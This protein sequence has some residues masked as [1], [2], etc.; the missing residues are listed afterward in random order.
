VTARLAGEEGFTLV[1]LLVA[2]IVGLVV[3]FAAF[4]VMDGSWRVNA[5]TTDHI[6]TTNRGRL[7]MDK[8]I[9]QLGSRTCLQSETPAQG[10]IVTATDNVIEYYASVTQEAAPRL[11]VE[12]RRLTYRP[13]TQDILLQAWTGTAPPPKPP[14]AAPTAAN[15][16]RVIAGGLAPAGSTPIFR[17]YAEEG[18]T[19]LVTA[20]PMDLETAN[21]VQLVKVT[22]AALGDKPEITTEFQNDSLTRS[23]IC[24]F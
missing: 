3:I 15:V 19:A 6:E 8:I 5:K 11:V 7:A 4:A 22:F 20:P 12:R 23:P 10:A 24:P 17:Y 21:T 2:M 1:E 14:P 9:Q 13:A 18:T 16:S